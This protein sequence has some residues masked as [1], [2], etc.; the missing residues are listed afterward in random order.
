MRSRRPGPARKPGP[1]RDPPGRRRDI[2]RDRGGMRNLNGAMAG[3]CGYTELAPLAF[4]LDP[5]KFS[6][7]ISLEY[8]AT[9]ISLLQSLKNNGLPPS[10]EGSRTRTAK[11]YEMP[12]TSSY[13]APPGSVLPHAQRL[14]FHFLG[15]VIT[16]S[17]S[18][19][20]GRPKLIALD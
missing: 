9:R 10:W 15:F 8:H 2:V 14:L 18:P 13:N 20:T 6:S 1:P 7:K 19:L 17:P 16:R 3:K 11:I 4:V 5:R 12:T